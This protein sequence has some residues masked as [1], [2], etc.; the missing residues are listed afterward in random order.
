M[1]DRALAWLR[2]QTDGSF[3]DW[4]CGTGRVAHALHDQGFPVR[5]VDI[6]TNAYRGD[7]PFVEAC[8][9]DL[10]ASLPASD[11]GYCADVMEHIPPAQVQATLD[12][13]A[14]RTTIACYFQIAMFQ[15]HHGD[16]I[17]QTLHLSVFPAD[18]WKRRILRSF[19]TAEFK[20]VQGKHLLAVA[21]P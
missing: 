4:G 9:W 5:L 8:L 15:D 14:L 13:I 16:A 10:P 2:P 19:S 3:T 1:L 17:G 21:K 20:V 12:G 7:L 6:A 18:W 11:Y